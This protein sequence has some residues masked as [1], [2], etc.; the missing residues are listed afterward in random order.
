M[1]LVLECEANDVLRRIAMPGERAQPK[2]ETLPDEGSALDGQDLED[3]E[4]DG[5]DVDE[6]LV[7]FDFAVNLG[8]ILWGGA[9]EELVT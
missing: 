1:K 6:A 2:R 5:G 9:V 7:G 4:S 8:A 3:T